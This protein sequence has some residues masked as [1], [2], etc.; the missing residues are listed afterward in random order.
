MKNTA[1][2]E[3]STP[4]NPFLILDRKP[5]LQTLQCQPARQIRNSSNLRRER[6]AHP[7]RKP[8]RKMQG[9]SETRRK[10]TNNPGEFSPTRL[11]LAPPIWKT[12]TVCPGHLKCRN[13]GCASNSPPKS[14]VSIP[15]QKLGRRG[16]FSMVPKRHYYCPNQAQRPCPSRSKTDWM[17]LKSI[18]HC[19]YYCCVVR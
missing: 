15:K 12:D 14:H 8:L 18:A 2:L 17:K 4:Y 5:R 10:D 16:Y 3:Q 13:S 7:F 1:N 9:M 6:R 11:I 19:C